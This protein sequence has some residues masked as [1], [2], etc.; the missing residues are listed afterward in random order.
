VQRA[1]LCQ[2]KDKPSCHRRISAEL[3]SCSTSAFTLLALKLSCSKR[4]GIPCNPTE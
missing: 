4:V 3:L 1:G 2:Q